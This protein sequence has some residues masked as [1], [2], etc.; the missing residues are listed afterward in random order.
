MHITHNSN[1]EHH[2]NCSYNALPSKNVGLVYFNLNI[3]WLSAKSA[4]SIL[5]FHAAGEAYNERACIQRLDEL[6]QAGIRNCRCVQAAFV[7]TSHDSSWVRY[8]SFLSPLSYHNPSAFRPLCSQFG[9]ERLSAFPTT[10][11][12]DLD[13]YDM[14][15]PQETS[16]EQ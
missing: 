2:C 12:L 16:G 8:L 5:S 4:H 6:A 15:L 13:L 1:H 9:N 11:V 14:L 10:L 7:C 3:I